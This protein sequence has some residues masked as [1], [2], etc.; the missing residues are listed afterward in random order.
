MSAYRYFQ[1]LPF[2]NTSLEVQLQNRPIGFKS[3]QK[4]PLDN[5]AVQFD[6]FHVQMTAVEQYFLGCSLSDRCQS[7]DYVSLD[8]LLFEIDFEVGCC[9]RCNEVVVVR[10]SV[11]ITGWIHNR[12]HLANCLEM[13]K[14]FRRDR[15]ESDSFKDMLPETGLEH[16]IDLLAPVLAILAIIRR[17]AVLSK[18]RYL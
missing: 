11:G 12:S 8:V 15:R 2:R 3:G 1:F 10:K 17:E 4:L 9:F 14:R 5:L 6:V 18:T 7:E 16:I 13:Q